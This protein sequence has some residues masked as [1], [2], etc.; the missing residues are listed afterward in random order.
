[1]VVFELYFIKQSFL[2]LE[3][4]GERGMSC[5]NNNQIRLFSVGAFLV[6]ATF[7]ALLFVATTFAA[8]LVLVAMTGSGRVD[9]AVFKI[10]HILLG[11]EDGLYAL[12]IFGT[13]VLEIAHL[14]VAVGFA[15]GIVG[16]FLL[17]VC[18]TELIDFL[19]LL[20][21]EVETFERIGGRAAGFITGFHIAT[22]S[23]GQAVLSELFCAFTPKEA[24]AITER[25]IKIFFIS[26]IDVF[27]WFWNNRCL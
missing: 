13:L 14:L 21:G 2:T 9:I 10:L 27:N 20:F 8:L 26:V 22:G 6:I 1:M 17:A 24:A 19:L 12:E 7:L 16:E 5:A 4:G 3:Y 25:A 11:S 15:N 23:L 18:L